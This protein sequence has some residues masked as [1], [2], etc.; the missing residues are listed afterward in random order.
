MCD[1]VRRRHPGR[2]LVFVTAAS[3]I[4][5]VV[6]ARSADLVYANNSW[7]YPFTFP[8]SLKLFGLIDAVYNPRTT[9]EKLFTSGS[10]TH[11]IDDLAESCGL[12]VTT[13]LPKLSPSPKLIEK[14]RAAHG[15]DGKTVA[16]RLSIGI[17]PGPSWRV[18]EWE[19]AKWQDL[20]NKIHATYHAVIIQFGTSKSDRSPD[21]NSLTGVISLAGQLRGDELVALIAVCD[22]MISIDSGPVHV[23]GAVGTPVV[24]L[25]GA[26]DPGS[27]LPPG[28]DAVGLFSDVPC[29]FCH[30]RTPVIHWLDGCPND[31]ACMKELDVN[32]VFE[33]VRSMLARSEERQTR[34]PWIV[35]G[36]EVVTP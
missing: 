20:I 35:E 21:Y 24:G 3:W 28:A 17:N 13:R 29:S 10:G 2:L 22:L 11:L 30:N 26:L 4:D 16:G 1:E 25:F 12:K 14:S 7:I 5:V 8:S 19:P 15:L 36:R 18:R 6:M 9:G 34:Q 32:T 23:A 31:I 27:R 33:A